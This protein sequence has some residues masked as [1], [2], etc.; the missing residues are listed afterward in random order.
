MKFTFD[1]PHFNLRKLL[2]HAESLLLWIFTVLLVV[3]VLLGIAA[4]YIRFDIVFADE[5]GKYLFIWLCMIGISAAT[6]DNQH[7]RLTFI[8]SS[9]PF[10]RKIISIISQTLFLAF[11]L[12]FVYWSSR[13]ALMHFEMDKS[14]M[15]F[16]FPMYWFTIALPIGFALT[17]LRLTQDIVAILKNREPAKVNTPNEIVNESI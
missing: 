8:S 17:S 10:S 3:D 13:L 5:L 2:A 14:V 16:H 4:R 6:K 11:S 7:V 9:L 1:N 15:G 12:F